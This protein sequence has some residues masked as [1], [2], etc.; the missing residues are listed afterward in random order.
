[1]IDKKSPDGNRSENNSTRRLYSKEVRRSTIDRRLKFTTTL[2]ITSSLLLGVSKNLK[3]NVEKQT[4]SGK[5]Q[6]RVALNE[7]QSIRERIFSLQDE[8]HE[9]KT[10]YDVLVTLI[11][12]EESMERDV[13][14]TSTFKSWMDYQAI[15]SKSSK[16]YQLQQLAKTDQNYGFRMVDGN[17]LVAMGS[18]Y[19]PVGKKYI[20]QFEDGKVINAMI[21]DIKHEGCES[22]G[23]NSMIE[24]IVDTE[25]LPKFL[26]VSGNF[27]Q[28]FSGSITV[29]REVD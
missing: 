26:R 4:K 11:N 6:P 25:V 5:E 20:I 17:L 1:M 27:N 23:D 7:N 18:Q 13:C 28:L 2:F 10:N 29:I 22:S 16:Q 9:L 19:G 14:S 15:T 21:G 8:N 3:R 12:N 24:F